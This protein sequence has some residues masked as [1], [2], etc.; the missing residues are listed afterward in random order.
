MTVYTNSRYAQQP[1]Y[2]LVAPNG[3]I[4]ATVFRTPPPVGVGSYLH[5]TVKVGDRFD[6]LAAQFLGDS[7]LWWM[8]ADANPEAFYPVAPVPGSVL[9]IPLRS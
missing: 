8:V 7:T 2:R 3:S 5:Y 9:R 4:R 1:V 6:S